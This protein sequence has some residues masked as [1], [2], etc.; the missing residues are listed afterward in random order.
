VHEG[1]RGV[2]GL[3][4]LL[5]NG[6]LGVARWGLM[7]DGATWERWERLRTSPDPDPMD[8]L[9]AV[10]S[11][12]RYFKAVER[13]AIQAARAQGRTWSEIG[14]VVGKTRQAVWQAGRPEEVK[15]LIEE[16]QTRGAEVRYRIGLDPF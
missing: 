11:F 1:R 10:A 14:S 9:E 8:V 15:R 12:Q 6:A 16:G 13:Q 5:D 4:R 7:S 3:S 2:P